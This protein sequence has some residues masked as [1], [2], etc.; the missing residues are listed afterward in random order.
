MI[1]SIGRGRP[2]SDTWLKN[3][4]RWYHLSVQ[5]VSF[6]PKLYGQKMRLITIFSKYIDSVEMIIK[7]LIT[8]E[9]S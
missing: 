3:H 8:S 1:D 9:L 2:P 6:V 5:T 4:T 7:Q